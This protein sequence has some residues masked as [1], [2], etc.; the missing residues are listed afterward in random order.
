MFGQVVSGMNVVQ[1]IAKVPTDIHDMPRIPVTVFDCGELDSNTGQ[2]K[3]QG[4]NLTAMAKV[5]VYDN[6]L[7][8][9]VDYHSDS[10]LDL[11]ASSKH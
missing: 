3:K 1:E 9:H 7:Q 11:E 4:E 10:D 5:S 6:A 2:A 8:K